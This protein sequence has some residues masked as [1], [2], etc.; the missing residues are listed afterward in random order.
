MPV[1]P[2][3]FPVYQSQLPSPNPENEQHYSELCFVS[4]ILGIFGLILPLF[5]TLAI[6][7]AIAGL[8]QLHRQQQLKGR[9][10]AV[11][12]IILGFIGIILIL[13][14]ILFGVQFLQTY[15]QKFGGLESLMG[16]AGKL[17]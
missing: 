2:S 15:L 5:S 7:I 13:T 9:W 16:K 6:I 12:G 8:M 3:N 17:K 11:T 1:V 4:L 10:M 14:A